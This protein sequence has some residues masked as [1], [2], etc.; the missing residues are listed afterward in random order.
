M[1]ELAEAIF[2]LSS[3]FNTDIKEINV[4]NKTIQIV[5]MPHYD[6][7]ENMIQQL[8]NIY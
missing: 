4:D 8:S 5:Q 1:D 3:A 2:S 7:F 6:S